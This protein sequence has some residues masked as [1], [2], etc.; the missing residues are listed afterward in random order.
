MDCTKVLTILRCGG[1]IR[2]A[3]LSVFTAL[4]YGYGQLRE[5]IGR[6][7]ISVRVLRATHFKELLEELSPQLRALAFASPRSKKCDFV[8][9]NCSQLR[10]LTIKNWSPNRTTQSLDQILKSCG[11]SLTHLC[12]L[13]NGQ[14]KTEVVESITRNCSAIE[15]LSFNDRTSNVKMDEFWQVIGRTLKR[16]KCFSPV[17]PRPSSEALACV[18]RHCQQL[19]DVEIVCSARQ[20]PVAQ[21]YKDMGSR[22]R[23]LRL[24]NRAGILTPQVLA[25]VLDECPNVIVDLSIEHQAEEML[26]ALGGRVRKLTL[27]WFLIPS[28]ELI[29]AANKL[30]RLTELELRG[31]LLMKSLK[32]VEGF[33]HTPRPQLTKLRITRTHA[34][35]YQHGG[36]ARSINV[37]DAIASTV[38]S[39]HEFECR[40]VN[41]LELV[42]F[43]SLLKS[44]RKLRR[45][46]VVYL[47][48]RGIS[49]SDLEV[50][51]KRLVQA[52]AKYES[53]VEF[54]VHLNGRK[55][56]SEEIRNACIPLRGRQLNVIAGNVHY[57]PRFH[58]PY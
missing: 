35:D 48:N 49:N 58:S 54:E 37:L 55:I 42:S 25:E 11:N 31:V 44:N 56:V 30:T 6:E 41:P 33:F 14:M 15:S 46:S 53:L 28:A 26:R 18:T 20:F 47:Y 13:G 39:L 40:S 38:H 16:L 52:L 36:L 45:F 10:E 50:N 21:F 8:I 17:P 9:Q 34:F 29:S 57:L 51:V 43:E 23:V 4:V 5:R 12:I 27:N 19:E 3:G 24:G 32:F 7:Y 1:I 2:E 22:L